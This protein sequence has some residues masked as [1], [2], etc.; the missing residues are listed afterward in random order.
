MIMK[1]L[2]IAALALAA[3]LPAAAQDTYESARLLGSDLNGTARYVGMGGAMEALGADISVIG[4]NPA[5]IG[6]FRH[7]SVS[8]SFGLVAQDGVEK[9][10]G[11]GKTNM[12]FDQIGFVYSSRISRASFINLAFNYHKSRNFDQILSAANSLR[13]LSQNGLT[14]DKA[15]R[16]DV[17]KGGFYWDL[18]NQ[19]YVIGY[20][21]YASDYRAQTF[22]QSDY[23]NLNALMLGMDPNNEGGY[24]PWIGYNVADSYL[25]DRSHRG[26]ISDFDFNISGNSEDR[27]YWGVTIGL[28]DVNY[29]GFSIYSEGLLD[30]DDADAG[31][32]DYA[33]RREI[34]GTGFDVKAG[35]IFRPVEESPFRIGVSVSTPTWY[36]LTTNNDTEMNN[37][38]KEGLKDFM[39]TGE[40][41]KFRFY[42]PWKLGASLG[43]TLGSKVALG[44]SYEY[45]NY[46]ASTN[47]IIDGD[48]GY[49]YYYDERTHSDRVMEDNTENSLKA[50]H[51]L[52][53][54]AELKP[55]PELSVRLGYNYVSPAYETNGMRDMTLDSPGVAYS[56]TTDYVNWQATNR[57]TCGLGYR[58]GGFSIDLAYQYSTTNGDFHPFQPYAS[59]NSGVTEVSNKRHQLLMTLGYTF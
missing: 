13:N 18:N 36:E 10:D 38:S 9:F 50:V 27:F 47:R 37:D 23:L 12:S 42:T 28:H 55:M 6:L 56:S 5:G 51:T 32:V 26:W 19:D 44:A 21:D 16:E 24:D 22:S 52:K 14:Y 29:K 4:T 57:F 49:G 48:D 2:Y 17:R 34:E 35:F 53:L 46:G 20:E 3:V 59:G 40:G 1:R 39:S 33:D 11:L 58:T 15:E 30:V 31:I 54:G 25:F 43:H 41:Y 8:T 7:S 45:S